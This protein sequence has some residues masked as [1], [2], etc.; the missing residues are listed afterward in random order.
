MFGLDAAERVA[1]PAVLRLLACAGVLVYAGVGVANMLLG[2]E[3]LDY[4]S[5]TPGHPAHG[6][7]YGILLVELGVGLTVSASMALIF[8][9]FSGRQAAREDERSERR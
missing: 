3:F 5:F 1:P 8:F 9:A 7:H 6:E 2:A 4:G